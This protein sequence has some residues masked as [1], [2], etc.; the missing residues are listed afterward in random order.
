MYDEKAFSSC[1]QTNFGSASNALNELYKELGVASLN[2]TGTSVYPNRLCPIS[3]RPVVGSLEYHG[4][5]AAA[6]EKHEL[7]GGSLESKQQQCE[8]R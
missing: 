8:I 7:R 5:V 3:E 1:L 2:S 4:H 6:M